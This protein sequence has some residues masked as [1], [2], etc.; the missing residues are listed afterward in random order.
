VEAKN[1]TGFI[2]LGAQKTRAAGKSVL[3]TDLN[4]T[5]A[6]ALLPGANL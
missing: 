5:E 1:E 2:F 4:I 6:R 3:E